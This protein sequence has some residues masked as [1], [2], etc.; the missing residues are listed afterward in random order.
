MA[1]FDILG[2][3]VT[4]AG[5]KTIAKTKELADTTR[6]NS[7]ISDEEKLNETRFCKIGK[8]YF[9][10]HKEDFEDSF[11]ELMN[12]VIESNKRI[13]EFKKN[14]EDI[15]GTIKCPSCGG[16]VPRNAAFCSCCGADMSLS[17]KNLSDKA[18]E[19]FIK[20]PNCSAEV[21]RD[22]VFCTSCG[23]RIHGEE[24]NNEAD[25]AAL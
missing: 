4:E 7:M 16:S 15:K 5:Q 10:L 22:M 2:K 23:T 11:A 18:E 13:K 8:L 3:T 24:E 19:S 17:N 9:E 6:L 1:F 25:V 14:I 20:C 21:D 12:S